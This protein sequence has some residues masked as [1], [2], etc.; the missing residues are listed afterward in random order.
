MK[1]L[2]DIAHHY[3]DEAEEWCQKYL[4]YKAQEEARITCILQLHFPLSNI[5]GYN[6]AQLG[7][8]R[9]STFGMFSLAE[10]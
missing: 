2:L 10:A 8:T 4:K 5:S 7:K 9:S 6:L 1:Q 3:N